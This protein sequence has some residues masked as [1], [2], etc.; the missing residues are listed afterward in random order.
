VA[1]VLAVTL[2]VHVPVPAHEAP[3]QP[4]NAEP[5]PGVAVKVTLDPELNRAEQVAP[6][7]I[8]AGELVTDP[9]PVPVRPTLIVNCGGGAGLK[10]AVTL[11]LDESVTLHA[12]V[13]EQAPLHPPNTEPEAGVAARLTAVP[14][15]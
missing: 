12:P 3:L 15:V 6:Q 9:E 10:V 2:I 14:D 5:D 7:L 1:E 13:P 4:A 11:W 8:P